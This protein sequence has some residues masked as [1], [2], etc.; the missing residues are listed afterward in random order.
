V[1]S[2]PV[3]ASVLI[4]MEVWDAHGAYSGKV[5]DLALDLDNNRV[6]FVV[7]ENSAEHRRLP[8]HAFTLPPDAGHLVLDRPQARIETVWDDV[9]PVPASGLIGRRFSWPQG[10]PAGRVADVVLDAFWGEVAFAAVRIGDDPVLRPVPLDA[11]HAG[12][13]FTLS[14]GRPELAALPGFTW[15]ELRAG[16]SDR[17][18]LQHTTRMAHQLTPLP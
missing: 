1:F 6:H 9:Y 2:E 12:R 13:P 11:F 4:G 10:A 14:V 3:R 7:L 16:I 17:S 5:H 18:F 15:E 8:M